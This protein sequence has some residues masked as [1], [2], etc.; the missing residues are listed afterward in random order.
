MYINETQK[1][2]LDALN[3]RKYLKLSNGIE[4]KAINSRQTILT[5]DG[6]KF[7]EVVYQNDFLDDVTSNKTNFLMEEILTYVVDSIRATRYKQFLD[8]VV[9]SNLLGCGVEYDKDVSVIKVAQVPV[10]F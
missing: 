3:Q 5:V 2:L 1:R 9:F 10:A 7:A 4:V 8:K 6:E